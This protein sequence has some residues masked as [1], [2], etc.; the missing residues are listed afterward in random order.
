M[1]NEIYNYFNQPYFFSLLLST[2][3]GL[4]LGVERAVNHKVASIRTFA[5]ICS[6]SCL[7]TLVSSQAVIGTN[8][9]PTRI[10][11][12]ILTGVG[13][14]GGGVIFKSA[15]K[16]EGITTGSMIWF[17]AAIG[18]GCGFGE[19]G[20]AICSFVLYSV[21]LGVGKVVHKL[22]DYKDGKF[23]KK[24]HTVSHHSHTDTNK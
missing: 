9:D 17:V 10:A 16:V 7:F 13:F 23:P 20:L 14:L 1:L 4:L 18:M 21:I 15:D 2:V 24:P 5:L 6:G 3:L 19:Y 12:N 11:S 8:Y 22:V